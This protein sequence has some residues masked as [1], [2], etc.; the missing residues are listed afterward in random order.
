M[1]TEALHRKTV[2]QSIE[3]VKWIKNE[4]AIRLIEDWMADQSGYDETIW[5][6]LKES[7][8]DNRLSE[9]KKFDE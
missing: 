9:R 6:S 3:S 2:I 8:E 4:M 7:I 5:G 1:Q